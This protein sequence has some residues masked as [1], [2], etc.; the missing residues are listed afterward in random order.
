MIR[1][2]EGLF[3]L[4][5]LALGAALILPV[6]KLLGFFPLLPWWPDALGLSAFLFVML[7]VFPFMKGGG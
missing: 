2:P 3:G 4:F 5:L 7:M 6:S 1:R